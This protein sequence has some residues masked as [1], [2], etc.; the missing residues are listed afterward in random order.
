MKDTKSPYSGSANI[1]L[2]QLRFSHNLSQLE[3]GKKL[4]YTRQYIARVESGASEGKR[5]FWED[6]QTF[7]NI[8][9][10]LMWKIYKGDPLS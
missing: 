7:F 2:Q 6:I 4:G 5:T 9:D 3:L 1:A 10:N 8:P